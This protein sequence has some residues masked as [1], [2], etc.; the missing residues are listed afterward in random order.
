MD[1]QDEQK[2]KEIIIK[3]INDIN[4]KKTGDTPLEA[5]DL[6]NR[7]YLQLHGTKAQ[8]PTAGLVGKMFFNT[9]SAIINSDDGTNWRDA[10]GN[11][12]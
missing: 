4:Q 10:A 3:I 1:K 11:I 7:A 6:V 8:R 2:I 5:F 9:D 12:V